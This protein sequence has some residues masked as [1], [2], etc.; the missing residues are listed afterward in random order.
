MKNRQLCAFDMRV[1]DL[2][3]Q[4]RPFL[5]SLQDAVRVTGDAQQAARSAMVC[6]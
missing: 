1:D 5:Y 2:D 3:D 6:V 4:G